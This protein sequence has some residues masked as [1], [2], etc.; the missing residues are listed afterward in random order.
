MATVTKGKTFASGEVVTPLKLH[1]M[2][3]AATV[4]AIVN[5]DISATA[6]IAASK[7][8]STLDL[9]SNTVTLPSGCV[10]ATNITSNAVEEAK[11]AANAVTSGKIASGAVTPSKL[12]QPL[13]LMTSQASTSG[14]AIDFTGIPSWVNRITVM[15]DEVSTDSTTSLVVQLG[16]SGGIE[17]SGYNGGG[18]RISTSTCAGTS[19]TNGFG[20][21]GPNGF[22]AD[23]CGS[24]TITRMT[25]NTWAAFG[26]IGTVASAAFVSFASGTKTLSSTL[27]RV[28]VTCSSGSFD[29]GTINVMY[30]G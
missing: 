8:A 5:A 25:G 30:E 17:T 22:G 16:D 23:A 3:D 2:V 27:D 21:N 20:F 7:L 12:S 9:S 18:A 6:A 13:T 29:K 15:F 28:R 1:E 10:A 24:L 11:I 4:T 19:F 26:A 14:S